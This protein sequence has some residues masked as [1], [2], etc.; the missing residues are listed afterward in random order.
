MAAAAT[1]SAPPA[2]AALRVERGLAYQGKGK[3]TLDV[4]RPAR[5]GGRLPGVMVVHGGTWRHG[6]G[7]KMRRFARRIARAGFVVFDV[8]YT[9]ATK[10]RGAFPRQPDDLRRALRWI[11]A[12]AARF[13]VDAQRIGAFGSSSGAHL[14][15]LIAT[16]GRGSLD[17]GARVR[18]AV[19]WS[20]PFDFTR[21]RRHKLSG[22]IR[23]FLG[24][25]TRRCTK[26]LRAASPLRYVTADDP[27]MLV[28]N[29]RDELMP[30]GQPRRMV[31]RLNAAGVEA[32]LA[33]VPGSR[34]GAKYADRQLDPTIAYLR[35]Q[36][37]GAEAP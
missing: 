2:A 15:A 22:A 26:R 5:S 30:L 34:H 13:K 11:R 36:L 32:K 18:A 21:L 14:V 35:E 27:A 33:L 3:P 1:A 37:A 10:A 9:Y 12:R 6:D 24:C 29:S 17:A 25:A 4:Y 19:T 20:A 16:K 28:V 31:N 7:G 23:H 8:G